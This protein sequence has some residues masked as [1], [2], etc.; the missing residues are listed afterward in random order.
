[1]G[2]RLWP[3]VWVGSLLANLFVEQSAPVAA[4]I[5]SG[6]ALQVLV[7]AS[8]I[9]GQIGVPRRFESVHQVLRFVAACLA[10]AVIAPTIGLAA[11]AVSSGLDAHDFAW[12][13]WTWWQGDACG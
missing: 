13:W 8:V 1:F 3:G 12:N 6:S 11:V 10:G 4:V 5:A 9:R 7:I 2:S